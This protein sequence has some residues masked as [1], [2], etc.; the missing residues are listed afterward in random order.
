MGNFAENLNLGNRFRPPCF[1]PGGA[2]KARFNVATPTYEARTR[3]LHMLHVQHTYYRGT[4]RKARD[5][6]I[7]NII[8]SSELARMCGISYTSQLGSVKNTRLAAR[9]PILQRILTARSSNKKRINQ[10]SF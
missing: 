4:Q 5:I 2:G 9:N 1:Q 7:H 6:V 3:P 10:A 8:C